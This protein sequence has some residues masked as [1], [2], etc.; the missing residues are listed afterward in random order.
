MR[1]SDLS[2]TTGIP[3]ATIKFYLREGL[4]QPGMRTGRNQARYSDQ[5]RRE[6]LLIRALTTVAQLDLTSVRALL[7]MVGDGSLAL[8]EMHLLFQ[9][10]LFPVHQPAVQS[11]NLDRAG[12]DIDQFM[13][14]F[15]WR[16]RPDAPAR[17]RLALVLATLR[18]LGCECPIDFFGPYLEAA[19][20]IATQELDLV[21][22]YGADDAAPVVVRSILLAVAFSAMRMLAEEH[23]IAGRADRGD[24]SVE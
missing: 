5:H 8:A 17:A 21:P 22:C 4:L 18:D 14:G 13:T 10:V 12:G 3:I 6:L 9:Q 20:R 7:A 16:V 11:E 2:R 19:E 15:G 23:V 24:V 1:I